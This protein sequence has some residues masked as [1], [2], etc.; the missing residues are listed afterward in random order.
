MLNLSLVVN[1]HHDSS[2]FIYCILIKINFR[3]H[4]LPSDGSG[5]D[6]GLASFGTRT[7]TASIILNQK[8][9]SVYQLAPS[10]SLVV[11]RMYLVWPIMSTAICPVIS[12]S[13]TTTSMTTGTAPATRAI[14]FQERSE[15]E[16]RAGTVQV[17]EGKGESEGEN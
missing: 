5:R 15:T 6:E 16:H 14:A 8:L 17:K 9:R 1:I 10:A 4:I 3:S 7:I 13:T 2:L 12:G 11:A